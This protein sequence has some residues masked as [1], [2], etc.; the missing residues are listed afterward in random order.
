MGEETSSGMMVAISRETLYM[1]A[2]RVTVFING[3]TI[4]ITKAIGKKVRCMDKVHL[5]WMMDVIMLDAS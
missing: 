1:I 3:L 2:W 4:Q 5:S